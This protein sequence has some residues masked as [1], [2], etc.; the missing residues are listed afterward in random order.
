MGSY[1]M[2]HNIL[3]NDEVPGQPIQIALREVTYNVYPEATGCVHARMA[4]NIAIL[5]MHVHVI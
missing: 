4:L 3:D 2:M 5:H 1:T